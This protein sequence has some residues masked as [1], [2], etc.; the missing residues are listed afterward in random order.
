MEQP[1][2]PGVIVRE[3]SPAGAQQRPCPCEPLAQEEDRLRPARADGALRAC[4]FC[5]WIRAVSRDLS[6]ELSRPLPDED[7]ASGIAFLLGPHALMPAG[8]NAGLPRFYAMDPQP[9]TV[10]VRL[11]GA[12]YAHAHD[13]G[14]AGG[15]A[16]RIGFDHAPRT[17]VV[18]RFFA[19]GFDGAAFAYRAEGL[20]MH[21]FGCRST[22]DLRDV[23]D[24]VLSARVP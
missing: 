21:E 22:Q 19:I 13:P 4:A 14:G 6:A 16:H 24:R 12:L 10:G 17:C 2:L 9:I 23:Y 1:T 5:A 15:L 11:L 8:G 18:D 3:A 7:G 20:D